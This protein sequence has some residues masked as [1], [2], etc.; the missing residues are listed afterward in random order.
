MKRS[1]DNMTKLKELFAF[2]KVTLKLDLKHLIAYPSSFWL[3]ALIVPLYS[4]LQIVFLETIF[5]Q[6]DNLLG[7]T[8]YQ[9]YILLGT[10]RIVQSTAYL[11]SYN[12]LSEFRQ[13]LRGDSQETFDMA[14]IKPINTMLYTTLGKYSIGNIAPAIIGIFIVRYGIIQEGLALNSFNVAGYL[15][16]VLMGVLLVY[17]TFLMLQT[18]LFWVSDSQVLESLWES[19]QDFGQYPAR[20]YQ[21]G[22]NA[23]FNIVLPVTL[24]AAIPSDYLL[25]RLP[26]YMLIIYGVIMIG[27]F[28][29][30]NW[31][32]NLSIKKYSSFSS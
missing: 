10:F 20:L 13:L 5:T 29:F 22:F 3:T 18:L 7:Y 15:I 12:R 11:F 27:L 6:T 14:L 8:K 30:A 25:G 32:W 28:L 4:L 21:G 19:Y 23:L 17:L 9:G 1:E 31:F 16:F 26:F 2:F 24:M